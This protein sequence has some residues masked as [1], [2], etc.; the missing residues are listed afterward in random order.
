[1]SVASAGQPGRFPTCA[2]ARHQLIVI[3]PR[4]T[5]TARR[6]TPTSSRAG[7]GCRD[8]GRAL[9]V[10]CAKSSTMR[11]SATRTCR[12]WR[13]C[14]RRSSR[15][16]RV[17]AERADVP[18]PDREAAPHLRARGP[19]GGHRG[20][21]PN[22]SGTDAARVSASLPRYRGGRWAASG[23]ARRESGAVVPRSRRW[24]KRS[25]RGRRG[26]SARSFASAASPTGGRTCRRPRSP[27]RSARGDGQCAR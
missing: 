27:T 16:P 6:A 13:R 24:R 21:G 11:R 7:L 9:G 3:D 15:S 17:V 5:E 22:M 2:R 8:R 19:R 20:T 25:D 26:A 23:R 18:P 10:I 4:R 14:A 1:M 12:A